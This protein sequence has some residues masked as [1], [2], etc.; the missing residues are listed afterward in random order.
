VAEKTG[1]LTVF[2]EA[3]MTRIVT[4]DSGRKVTAIEYTSG[5]G[6]VKPVE[7]KAFVLSCGTIETARHL[8]LNRLANS[9]GQVGR[10][11]TSHFGVTVVG[12]F[13]DL[14]GRDASNDD[15]TAY[16]HS[17]LTGLYWDRPHPKFRGTYQVQCGSGLNPLRL[18]V[19]NVPGYG[20]AFKRAFRELNIGHAGM[21]MQGSLL[22][23]SKKFV[24]LDPQRRD[25]YGL[26][27]ARVHLHYED[28]DLAM[29]EDMVETCHEIIRSGSGRVVSSPSRIAPETL[30]VDSNHWVGTARMGKDP[31]TSV[32]NTESRC[33][34]VANLYIGD[35]SVFPDYPE[36]NPTL[37]NIALSWRMAERL[38]ERFRRGEIGML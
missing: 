32:V 21:N 6:S 25:R 26:N 4:S 37:T 18:G 2:A 34:D 24:D 22:V 35:A 15:G 5:D 9:S 1:N 38:A 13:P 14:A 36:K 7:A 29:A 33:H 20:S 16:Y 12:F 31:K 10:N 28:N 3:M 17:L 8:L 11:L 23:S 30:V 19:R 27:V